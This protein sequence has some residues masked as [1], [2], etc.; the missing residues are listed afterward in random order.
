MAVR[1]D[2][3]EEVTFE[4]LRHEEKL[5]VIGGEGKFRQKPW[6]LK[7]KFILFTGGNVQ[8]EVKCH[9]G[10]TWVFFR[11]GY[12]AAHPPPPEE[13]LAI[14]PED[15]TSTFHLLLNHN[16]PPQQKNSEWAV[17]IFFRLASTLSS[18]CCVAL[19]KSLLLSGFSFSKMRC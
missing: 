12:G 16:G 9:A 3:P 15:L 2:F 6:L 14:F 1:K 4:M 19:Q 11:E 13:S 17:G 10:D 5:E 18:I 7:C 8:T